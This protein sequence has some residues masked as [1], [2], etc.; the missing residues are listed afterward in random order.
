MGEYRLKPLTLTPT[1][2]PSVSVG[3]TA[4]PPL[5][6]SI[7]QCD[8]DNRCTTWLEAYPL[9]LKTY[10]TKG[11]VRKRW[12]GGLASNLSFNQSGLR[13]IRSLDARRQ[14]YLLQLQ[15]TDR[16]MNELSMYA[17]EH[18]LSAEVFK[19]V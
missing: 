1:S 4:E 19:S 6:A 8:A 7:C 5:G 12:L 9:L 11:N 10:T 3:P 16:A 18:G 14:C 15:L 2:A 17:N 13:V